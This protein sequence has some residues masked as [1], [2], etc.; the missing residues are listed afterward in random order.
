MAQGRVPPS[1]SWIIS[2][3]FN[4]L[5]GSFTLLLPHKG[6]FLFM[7]KRLRFSYQ[8][9]QNDVKSPGKW[10]RKMSGW[11]C[12]CVRMLNFKKFKHLYPTNYSV[13]RNKIWC[14]GK[15]EAF[16]CSLWIP[17]KLIHE[18]R[19]YDILNFSIN[20]CKD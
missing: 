20:A 2:E 18:L 6:S 1:I 3:N 16:L 11:M 10:F 15:A 7:E 8:D 17:S 14:V 12:V 5:E 9:I 13:D 19:F 4:K